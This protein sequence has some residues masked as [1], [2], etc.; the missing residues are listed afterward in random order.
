MTS[1]EHISD[2]K[3][4][5]VRYVAQLARIALTDA[6]AE[7]LQ[8]QLE[9]VVSHVETLKKLDV[10]NVAPTT[11]MGLEPNI[12]REDIP[13]EPFSPQEALANSPCVRANLFVVP[14]V[15]E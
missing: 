14:K 15:V 6:E 9:H 8:S 2:S 10:S 5:D 4:I 11:D 12:F 7:Q 1:E 13:H 3:K